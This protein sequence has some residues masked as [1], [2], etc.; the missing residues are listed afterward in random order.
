MKGKDF[1]QLINKNICD[2]DDVCV[3]DKRGGSD[4]L[5]VFNEDYIR[6]SKDDTNTVILSVR[7][8]VVDSRCLLVGNLE[9]SDNSVSKFD[10]TIPIDDS[11]SLLISKFFKENPS[12]AKSL[13]TK[14]SGKCYDLITGEEIK[15]NLIN[16]G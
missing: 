15:V 8:Y 13:L 10:S 9:F 2:D 14:I 6:R 7:D 5:Y 3:V 4:C 16:R 11:K 12:I 1:K